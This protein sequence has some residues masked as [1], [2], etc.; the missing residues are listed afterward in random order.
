M[1]MSKMDWAMVGALLT[2]LT[3]FS[4][5]TA[6]F[7][8]GVADF[9]SANRSGGRYML[10]GA[11]GMSNI[12]AVSVV[13]LFEMY[14]RAGFTPVWWNMMSIPVWVIILFTGW[15]YYRFRE[16]RCLTMAQF[17]EAR[18]SRAF[19][20]YAGIVVWFSGV[21]NFGIFP[22]VSARFFVYY[23]GLPPHLDVL[24]FAVPTFIPVMVVTLGMALAYTWVGGQITV[25]VTDCVQG[26]FCM[27]AFL[28]LCGYLLWRFAW[29]DI[30]AALAMAPAEASMLDP[31]RTSQLKDFNVWYF[32]I[33]IFGSFYG[34]MS[35]QGSQAY[36]SSSL[37]PHEQKMGQMIGMWRGPT[38]L[39]MVVLLPMCAVAFLRL[40]QYAEGAANVQQVLNAIDNEA[41]RTQMTAPVALSWILPA[42]I[43]GLFCCVMVFYLIT[44]QDTYLHSWGSIFIQDV[45]LPFRKRSF[46][47]EA[48]VRLLRWS[49]AFVALFSFVFSI[50]FRQT[51]YVLMFFAITGA[52]VS[53]AGAVIVG[54]LYWRRGTSAAAWTAMTIG[55]VMAVG[56]IVLQQIAPLFD[57]IQNRGLMLGWID[58]INAINSQWIWFYTMVTCIIAY[59]SVSWLTCRRPFD[60]ERLLHRGRY[61]VAGDHVTAANAATSVWWRITGITEEFTRADR[62][63]A[64]SVLVW[65]FGWFAVFA[66]GT[67]YNLTHD[68]ALASWAAFWKVWVWIQLG[69]G[70]PTTLWITM[71]SWRD[72]KRLF[73]RL[74]REQRDV[75]DD[76]RVLHEG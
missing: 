14:Y 11:H 40:P 22:A 57:G 17:F 44:T 51:E 1:P 12:C 28:I 23:C 64:V 3:V 33:L 13:A 49:I 38:Q 32:L 55:W 52:I 50:I 62:W 72:I 19:R 46:A 65:N 73:V 53:G 16:T 31:H 25:M 8:K 2:A 70:V 48:H 59:V 6:R 61:A 39:A 26:M 7:M 5:W 76:G 24:G 10:A 67:V 4:V 66:V 34:Y 69:V 68:V 29:A 36:Q 47:P 15:V 60:M 20:V 74:E 71:G 43:K 58:R 18:Y 75:C 56:R 41:I 27:F 54:G 37:N 35:W 42:G 30:A 45:V 21:V 63:L 9:L